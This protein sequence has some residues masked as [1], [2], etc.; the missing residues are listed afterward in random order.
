MT[1]GYKA[2]R[3]TK[4]LAEKRARKEMAKFP[5]T[6]Q[7]IDLTSNIAKH[8]FVGA[9]AHPQ[10]NGGRKNRSG[11]STEHTQANID[12]AVFDVAKSIGG[13]DEDSALPTDVGK[14]R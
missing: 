5:P 6:L 11:N 4:H 3:E 14:E 8:A 7:T 13:I 10:G 12:N 2:R 9:K 1:P